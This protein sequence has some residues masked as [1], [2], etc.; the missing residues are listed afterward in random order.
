MPLGFHN[1]CSAGEQLRDARSFTFSRSSK[2]EFFKMQKSLNFKMLAT[3]I[4]KCKQCMVP[5]TVSGG[6]AGLCITTFNN[7]QQEWLT[8]PTVCT[9]CQVLGCDS[10]KPFTGI[11][12]L[13]HLDNSARWELLSDPFHRKAQKGP[14]SFQC[15]VASPHSWPSPAP[16]PAPLPALSG[17]LLF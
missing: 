9:L 4:R 17:S 14:Q 2:C 12:P 6:L 16:I 15:S 10:V 3:H 8:L 1:C 5:K 7:K 11:I 13:C